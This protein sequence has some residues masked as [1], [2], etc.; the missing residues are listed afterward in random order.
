MVG[1]CF[2]HTCELPWGLRFPS[3]SPA[4]EW[5]FREKLLETPLNESLAVHPTQIYESLA[6]L[7]IA[8]FTIL[9]VQ[10]RKRYDG[11]VFVVFLVLYASSRFVIEFARSDDRGGWLFLST[12]QW[13][14]LVMLAVAL[15]IHFGRGLRKPRALAGVPTFS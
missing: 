7:A 1:C 11:Q 12:S 9:Y 3:H 13:I 6:A 10:G 15:V 2:G 14:G 5:Q 4:S 8:A